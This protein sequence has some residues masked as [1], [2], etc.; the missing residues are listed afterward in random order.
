MQNKAYPKLHIN[1]DLSYAKLR[2]HLKGKDHGGHSILIYRVLAPFFRLMTDQ[3]Y[4]AA[5]RTWVRPEVVFGSCAERDIQI[6]ED[7]ESGHR[8][9]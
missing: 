7:P 4:L 2:L 5:F 8:S 1:Y 3:G 9:P 6:L